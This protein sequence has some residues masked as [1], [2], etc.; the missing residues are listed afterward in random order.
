MRL[1]GLVVRLAKLRDAKDLGQSDLG[2]LDPAS[3][4][5]RL[6]TL[7]Q[8][9]AA[10]AIL[11]QRAEY[12]KREKYW[13]NLSATLNQIAIL[14][15]HFV[16]VWEFQAHNLSYNVSVEF[17]DYRQRYAWVKRGMN[18]LIEGSKY[19]KKRT[20]MPYE[21]GWFYGNKFGVSDEKKQFREL[22][23]ND[24]NYHD[25]VYERSGM[26]LTQRAA[27]GPDG[28]PDN[29]RVGGLWYNKAYDMVASGSK[30]AKSTM[31]FYRMGPS[32]DMKHAE[33]IQ[34]E[35]Y[36]DEAARLAWERAEKSWS[37][38]GQRQIPTTWGDVIFLNELEL[39]NQDY[40]KQ[41]AE[42]EEFCGVAFDQ[43]LAE[44]KAKLSPE[45]VAA[46]EKD[47]LTR[48]Y[49]EI[50]LA[51][52]AAAMLAIA[53]MEIAKATPSNIQVEAIQR[54]NRLN[55][56]QARI[57]HI[58]SYRNQINF[59]YW[60]ARCVAEQEDEAL[61]AR[62]NMYEANN[63]LDLGELDKALE[64]YE[65]AWTNWSILFNS[66]PAMMVDDSAENVL[67]SIERYRRLLD[68][69]DLP[70]DFALNDFMKFRQIYDDDLADPNL[71]SVISSWPKRYPD[72]NFL[73]EMLK[74]PLP[75]PVEQGPDP[76]SQNPDSRASATD[77]PATDSPATIVDVPVGEQPAE[78]TVN[79]PAEPPADTSPLQ[80]NPPETGQPPAPNIPASGIPQPAPPDSNASQ[81]EAPP[82]TEA[83]LPDA[84]QPPGPKASGD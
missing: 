60:D 17:D 13:D 32:W 34:E 65:V 63:L 53:P 44:R 16:K 84:G 67:D 18:Y 82:Q 15:P 57:E 21:L 46:V 75:Q 28:R 55:Q 77:S 38:F 70:D 31:M 37:E 74:K 29:W 83:N 50:I 11:W 48:T 64:K 69:P 47:E 49:D 3:E 36:L 43:L 35:G 20:E 27:E 39:A 12:Y 42:F 73:E 81:V 24:E 61:L 72:R 54:A 80:A 1:R 33:G 41:R 58:E 78:A 10:I 8:R 6:A 5:M 4:S 26:D 40:A 14:Q 19:N 62:T 22:F 59:A 71:M 52:E 66:H 68:Q 56:A 25:Q 45:Q 30:P 23:R 76:Y 9:G 2:Q 7:G 79:I 51:R